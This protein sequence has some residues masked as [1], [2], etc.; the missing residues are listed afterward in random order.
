MNLTLPT[1]AATPLPLPGFSLQWRD[2]GEISTRQG[3][4]HLFVSPMLDGWW[5]YWKQ[6]KDALKKQGFSCGKDR[7]GQWQVTF[8]GASDSPAPAPSNYSSDLLNKSRADEPSAG[9]RNPFP[10]GVAPY[11]YQ[12]AGIEYA[13]LRPRCVIAD[14]MGLG[15]T[16][17]AIGV[18]NATK[19]TNILVV[20]PASLRFNWRNELGKFSFAG[21]PPAESV[22]LSKADIA[23]IPGQKVVIISYDLM[24]SA[25]AQ[26][27]LR[28]RE[29]DVVIA[30]EAHYLKNRKAKRSKGLLGL[31]PRAKGDGPRTPIAATRHLFLTGTPVSNQPENFWNV[32]RFCAAEHFG[33]WMN[34]AKKFCDAR[35]VP[36]GSGWDTTG[37][38]NL[39]E[40]QNLVRGTCMVRRL[41]KQVLTQLPSKTRKIVGLPTPSEVAKEL[42]A[43]TMEHRISDET[44]ADLHRRIVEAEE[45]GDAAG[46]EEATG[47]LRSAAQVLFT[48]TAAVRKRIGLAKVE[49]AIEH[50]TNALNGG[51]KI[52][53]GAHHK[54]VISQLREGL[55][56]FSPAVVTG[57][58]PPVDRQAAVE[59]FQ[60]DESCRVFLGNILAAGT[61]ITLT[62]APHVVIV[63]PDWVPANN[64]QFEDRAHRIGQS[65][66]VMVEYLAMEGTI[67]IQILKANARKMDTIEQALDNENDVVL[68]PRAINDPKPPQ[69][70]R[71]RIT[72]QN[73]EDKARRDRQLVI[74]A[75][76]RG[77]SPRELLTAHACLRRVA[78]LDGDRAE[79]LNGVG[80]SKMDTDYGNQL[81]ETATDALSES[82][83]GRVAIL[84]WKYRRQAPAHLV[85]ILKQPPRK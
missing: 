74:K 28:D 54:D 85:E 70:T 64:L 11:G 67:D 19:A 48:E 79:A 9:F 36:F 12:L 47:K 1:G 61:G 50:I 38:S 59:R 22:V 30:D 17:Q 15:K 75:F 40:L 66:P 34:F 65:Q 58:T 53:V 42:D 26:K 4:R 76:G 5:D 20:C 2:E 71:E 84:A 52:I 24:S 33:H 18:C 35:K 72:E 39:S 37:K 10:P 69:T 25:A 31:P 16:L 80:F 55:E 73:A 45:A 82:Q 3:P 46:F 43:L 63:E 6:H 8:W 57:S 29:W 27:V 7:D 77:L 44:L 83:K 62:A 23:N 13:L 21:E 81:A 56:Q 49:L 41:K 68:D 78:E 60:S 51:G 14:D 32:L